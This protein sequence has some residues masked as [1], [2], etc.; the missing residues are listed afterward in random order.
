[1]HLDLY[2]IGMNF[3]IQRWKI[4]G[5]FVTASITNIKWVFSIFDYISLN[6]NQWSFHCVQ[7]WKLIWLV[8][9]ENL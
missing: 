5:E 1:M 7:Q 2:N 3:K 6:L 4:K 8:N 9:S